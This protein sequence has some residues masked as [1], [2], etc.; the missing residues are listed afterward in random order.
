MA[1]Q[2]IKVCLIRRAEGMWIWAAYSQGDPETDGFVCEARNYVPT[3]EACKADAKRVAEG[4]LAH[5]EREDRMTS[6]IG[7]IAQRVAGPPVEDAELAT[8]KPLQRGPDGYLSAGEL[9]EGKD[10]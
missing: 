10:D 9:K 2:T 4:I 7:E 6:D 1:G 5:F 3:K 8:G